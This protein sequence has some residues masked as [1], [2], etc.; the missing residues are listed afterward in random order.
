MP[1]AIW[2]G[3]I[4]FGLVN[5]PVK[6]YAATKDQ[7][8]HFKTLCG[9]CHTPLRYLRWCPNCRKEVPWD[10]IE[11]GYELTKGKFVVLKKKE[12]EGLQLKSA[13]TIDIRRFVD[14]AAV[15]SLYFN[16]H[17]Y[18]IPM[19]GGEKAYSLLREVLAL[20]NKIGIGKI[21]MRGKEHI[22]GIRAY[23]NGLLMSTLFYAQEIVPM[24]S[25]S[26]LGDL[27]K[28]GKE[29]L[30]LANVL[31]ERLSGEFDPGEFK[32][33]YREA[34]VEVIKQKARGVEPELGKVP[35]VEKTKDLMKALKASVQAVRK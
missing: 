31:V 16:R 12:L 7:A 21:V 35:K 17:Y 24:S 14:G 8:I 6:V 15:D 10:K 22:V 3:S 29:E 20:S 11:H 9:E 19:E 23:R 1:R 30:E 28:T 18:L 32:D 26:E 27:E 25:I 33:R 5:I 2:K 13:R 34:V 4:S